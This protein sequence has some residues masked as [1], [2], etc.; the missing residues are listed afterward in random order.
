LWHKNPES[1]LE[2]P[3]CGW[4]NFSDLIIED[5][6]TIKQLLGIDEYYYFIF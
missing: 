1:R 3:E 5:F 4:G 6:K 2:S